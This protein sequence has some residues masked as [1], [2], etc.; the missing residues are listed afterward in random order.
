MTINKEKLKENF[1]DKKTDKSNLAITSCNILSS[2][3]NIKSNTG[4]YLLLLIIVLL[5]FIFILFCSRG[6]INL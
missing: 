1:S 4:F 6:Y 2:K 3:E 5:I